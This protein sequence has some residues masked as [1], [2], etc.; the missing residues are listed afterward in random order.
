MREVE[1]EEWSRKL[2]EGGEGGGKEFKN[3]MERRRGNT[4][5]EESENY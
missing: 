3:M 1:F 4:E 2:E 5:M